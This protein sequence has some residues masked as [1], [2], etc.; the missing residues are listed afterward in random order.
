MTDP[1][2]EIAEKIIELTG[3]KSK[4]DYA[5]VRAGDVK[6]SQASIENLLNTDF[7][8]RWDFSDGLSKTIDFFRNKTS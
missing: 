1:I 6:H 2:I 3:S 5:P 8:P 7:K 4:I